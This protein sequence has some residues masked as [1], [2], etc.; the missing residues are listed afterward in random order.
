MRQRFKWFL[1]AI[2]LFLAGAS[3]FAEDPK[4]DPKPKPDKD[5]PFLFLEEHKEKP[6]PKT[7]PGKEP[8][9]E[10]GKESTEPIKGIGEKTPAA[11]IVAADR[12]ELIDLYA[13]TREGA[14]GWKPNTRVKVP[15]TEEGTNYNAMETLPVPDR[16]RIGMPA[17]PLR[18]KG[19]LKN[20]YRQNM[21]KGDYPII[22]QSTFLN[23]T[24]VSD[25]LVEGH[26][27][28]TPS[29]VTTNRPGS[30]DFFGK[31][32]QLVVKEDFILS[33][34]LFGGETDFKPRDWE[35]RVTP[36]FDLN[37][38][39]LRE[40]NNVK[41]DPR[42]GT[43]R[44]EHQVAFQELFGEKHLADLSDNYDFVSARGGIQFFNLN[45]RGF[46]FADNNLGVR[47]FGNYESNR[48]QY[49]LAY[50]EMLD[51]DTNSG[52]N[53]VFERK[54]EHVIMAN[55]IRQDTFVKGYDV[56]GSLAFSQ[57]DKSKK[58]NENGLIVRPAP[59]GSLQEH[60]TQVGYAGIG[61]NGHIGRVNI[62]NQFYEAFGH[63]SENP[64]AGRSQTINAQMAALELSTDMDWMR[65]RGSYFYASGDRNP[66][67]SQANGF[68]AIFDDPNF[69]GGEFSYWV[70]QGLPAG[71]SATLL[72]S[73][74]S[75]L[76]NLNTT[77]EE[78]QASF[79]NPG[80]Q[81]WNL[82]YDADILP[83]LKAIVN[84]NYLQ[85]ANTSSL[86]VL[87][88]QNKI[89]KEIGVDYSMGLVYRPFLNNQMLITAGAAGLSPGEGFRDIYEKNKTLYSGF[90]GVTL[91]Y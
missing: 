42:E 32:D 44:F 54:D 76:P 62:S 78:G 48:L 58:F 34:E 56:T 70:R 5:D 45:F 46:L 7:E 22:G 35:V 31:G 67:D 89:H 73:R 1:P 23:V 51:K 25:T 36:V 19:D 55:L 21:L 14:A 29:G 87:L 71:N 17:N 9:K 4:P 38:V 66:N 49:N 28:P 82:G 52:L 40:V 2:G 91:K 85:F 24:G 72:K 18:V 57:Q 84:V 50:F 33:M 26:N 77:K 43:E 90:I 30:F 39:K 69:A 8:V 41:I 81:L 12:E 65:F 47:G 61:G 60:E 86:S 11:P 59:I 16:W 13:D 53:T 15:Q 74:F 68:D 37:Y 6:K 88:G 80:L 20:P 3:L 27:T 75:L 10:P 83:N 63:D 64:L 79:V